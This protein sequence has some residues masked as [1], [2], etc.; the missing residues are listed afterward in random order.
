MSCTGIGEC[1]TQSSENDY[2][3]IYECIHNCIPLKCPNYLLCNTQAPQWYF[4]CHSNLC[5]NCNM[6]FAKCLNFK[7]SECLICL[8]EKLCVS[9]P[10]CQH[11]TCIDCFKRSYY[12][13]EDRSG[14]P[15]FPYS[16]EISDK[17]SEF[18]ERYKNDALIIKYNEDWNLWD[19]IREEKRNQER[20]YLGKCPLCRV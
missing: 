12:G 14:E 5:M 13:D 8:E 17:Y 4:Y 9:Q 3:E 15:D 16:D 1:L 11:Y 6:M 7:K 19:D 2:E 10:K 20:E 18:P